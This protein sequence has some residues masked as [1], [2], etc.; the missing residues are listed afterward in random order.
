MALST[1][2]CRISCSSLTTLIILFSRLTSV[3]CPSFPGGAG[4]TPSSPCC[5]SSAGSCSSRTTWSWANHQRAP[6][7]KWPKTTSDWAHA[8]CGNILSLWTQEWFFTGI[9]LSLLAANF[10]SFLSACR[11]QI[12]KIWNIL[13]PVGLKLATCSSD[14]FGDFDFLK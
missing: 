3:Q 8:V 13:W 7:T 6:P 9:K 10:F 5:R 12:H 4:S 14:K 2:M 11:I 1:R